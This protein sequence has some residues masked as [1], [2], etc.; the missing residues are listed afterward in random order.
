[1]LQINR[2][3]PQWKRIS[4]ALPIK[5]ASHFW[6]RQWTKILPVASQ[7]SQEKSKPIPSA[8]AMIASESI[9]S[10]GTADECDSIADTVVIERS[11]TV[12]VGDV[13]EGTPF[14]SDGKATEALQNCQQD[15][16]D[17]MFLHK[18]GPSSSRLQWLAMLKTKS[19][20]P[21]LH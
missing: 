14:A 6:K 20:H 17:V 11:D 19:A 16:D 4:K 7:T 18:I 2:P 10:E 3:R 9:F 8:T 15:S 1:M 5:L 13:T 12:G 21:M